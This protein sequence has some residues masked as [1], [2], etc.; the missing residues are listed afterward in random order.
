MSKA[1]VDQY[2]EGLPAEAVFSL[3]ALRRQV[4]EIVP[5]GEEC[6]SYAMPCVK[7]N[8]KAVAGYAAFKKHIGYFPHSGNIV[9]QLSEE[10]ANR[11][12]TTGGFQ[13]ELGEVLPDDLVGKLVSLR[14]KELG[15]KYPDM[16]FGLY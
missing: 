7:L 12:Q 8:G 5:N 9:P 3:Q 6:I 10:L 11:K 1:D 4:L 14:L 13:F 16:D 2:L 15:E